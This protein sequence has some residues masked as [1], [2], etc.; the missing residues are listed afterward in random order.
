MKEHTPHKKIEACMNAID[1]LAQYYGVNIISTV[2]CQKDEP[3]EFITTAFATKGQYTT[4]E[5][6]MMLY[7]T[8]DLYDKIIE[9]ELK[10]SV[11]NY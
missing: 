9:D 7:M 10:K 11:F 1:R 3:G 8:Y 4:D 5:L 6:D 2:T